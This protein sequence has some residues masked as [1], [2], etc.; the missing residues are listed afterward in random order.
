MITFIPLRTSTKVLKIIN[1]CIEKMIDMETDFLYEEF[2]KDDKEELIDYLSDFF[3]LYL[4]TF[5]TRFLKHNYYENK[6]SIF[7]LLINVASSKHE[8]FCDGSE[9]RTSD[10]AKGYQGVRISS[11]NAC[12]PY[13]FH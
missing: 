6:A 2:I 10:N 5:E 3:P 8:Y 1:E 12:P 4:C 13:C 11:L 9:R 7:L